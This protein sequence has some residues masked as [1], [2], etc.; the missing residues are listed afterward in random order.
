MSGEAGNIGYHVVIF[1]GFTLA[2]AI[3][4]INAVGLVGATG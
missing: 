4:A 2:C 3:D 1:F